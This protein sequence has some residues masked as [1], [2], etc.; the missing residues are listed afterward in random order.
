MLKRKT[1][2]WTVIGAIVLLG[3]VYF[4]FLRKPKVQYNTVAASKGYLTETVSVT[5]SLKA[6]D[7][8]GL[9]FE[10]SGRIKESK[11]VVGQKVA[12]GDVLA[13]LDQVN[14][15]NGLD[16]AKAN[17]DKARAD[18]GANSDAVHTDDVAVENAEK[19]LKDTKNLN[20]AKVESAD[21][22]EKDAKNKLNDAQEYYDQVKSEEG[23]SSAAAKSAKLT[24]DA[25]EGGYNSAKKEQDVVDQQ[26]DLVETEAQNNLNSAKANLAAVKSKYVSA[27]NNATV[28][29]FEAAYETALNNLDKA[30]LR[31][32]T[33]GVI[34]K[35][36]FKAG[37]V[38]G[39]PSIT[40]QESFFAEMISFDN[41]LEA[42][43][44]EVDIA[45]VAVGQNAKLIFDAL[46]D[47][48]FD[49]DVVSIEPSATVVQDVVDFVVK[50][51]L[52]KNDPR[53]KDGM[54]ADIDISINKK[55]EVI[56]IPQRAVLDSN[57][58]KIV[59]VLENGKPVDREVKLGLEGDGGLVEIVSGIKEG[60]QIITSTK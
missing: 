46:P 51:S 53:L 19:T 44:S 35:V 1:I 52:S 27:G 49:G 34:K 20:D 41:I 31:A 30:V 33:N 10:T 7:D 22:T 2:I 11:V 15:Q 43:V 6:N 54:S 32:P 18:A 16:Q 57:G 36:N 8:I 25:A 21:Q 59:Q 13:I 4:A 55:E 23:S 9:N 58:K 37:E 39:S 3:I 5:G 12:K 29:S 56:S 26:S 42:Q 28:K 38:I 45:K 47:D 48:S 24:L 14:L 40:S 60:E 50:I 17:L